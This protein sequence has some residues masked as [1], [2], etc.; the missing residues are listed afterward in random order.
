ML[1]R[2]VG[3]ADATGFAFRELGHCFSKI[4]LADFGGGSETISIRMMFLPFQV[5]EMD[6]PS[7]RATSLSLPAFLGNS[8][9]PFW[10][11]TGQWIR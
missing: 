2:E 4:I 3:H 6:T 7:S 11:A 1:N 5:S 8:S 10:K 9:L